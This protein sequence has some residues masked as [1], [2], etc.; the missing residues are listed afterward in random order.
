MIF[1]QFRRFFGNFDDFL[2]ISTIFWQFRRFFGNF[3]DF[4]DNFDDF[5]GQFWR[6]FEKFDNFLA[7]STIL[8]T[9]STIF[10]GNFDDFWGNFDEC[11]TAWTV[12][13]PTPTSPVWG[14]RARA[15]LKWVFCSLTL[16]ARCRAIAKLSC[17]ATGQ[18]VRSRRSSARSRIHLQVEKWVK[19][20]RCR[21]GQHSGLVL[22]QQRFKPCVCFNAQPA[23]CNAQPVAHCVKKWP[24]CRTNVWVSKP[25][26]SIIFATVV[27]ILFVGCHLLRQFQTDF[28]QK[29]KI[30]VPRKHLIEIKKNY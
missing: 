13:R 24:P 6:F 1:W 7:I 16:L 30:S 14:L 3:D 12:F 29:I 15:D 26:G 11:L 25:C 20:K 19:R 22:R 5:L 2:A 23:C 18:V 9:I 10:W 4:V 8:N 17:S 27:H 28:F 21:S